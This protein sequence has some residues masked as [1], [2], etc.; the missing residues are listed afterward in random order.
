[1]QDWDPDE[2]ILGIRYHVSMNWGATVGNTVS[3][4]LQEAPP[5]AHLIQSSGSAAY[6][7][8]VGNEKEIDTV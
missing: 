8:R 5:I 6:K 2:S 4:L 3:R 1:M 7:S